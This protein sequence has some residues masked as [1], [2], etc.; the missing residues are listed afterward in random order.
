M[1]RAGDDPE[2]H[3]DMREQLTILTIDLLASGNE[4][5]TAAITSGVKLLIE[6]PSAIAEVRAD[7]RVVRNLAEEILRLESP[8][9]GMFRRVTR[10]T[11][12]GGVPLHEGDLLSVRFGAANRD[13]HQFPPGAHRPASSAARQAPRARHRPPSLHRR[14]A[15]ATGDHQ[16]GTALLER[17]DGFALTPGRPALHTMSFS[18]ATCTRC[19][20]A[21][22][23][24]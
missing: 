18:A 19:T 6:N 1:A 9:Q 23:R 4:T 22:P 14:T 13:E 8:A 17:Y 20:D 24:G 21:P 16:R 7:P 11:T 5:T 12:L 3:F 15:R 10:D 2:L